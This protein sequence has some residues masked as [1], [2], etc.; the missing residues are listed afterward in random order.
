MKDYPKNFL[1][2]VAIVICGYI[3]NVYGQDQARMP[4][5]VAFT[6][7]EINKDL[8]QKINEDVFLSKVDFVNETIIYIFE[9]AINNEEDID[10]YSS[11]YSEEDIS[12]L[13]DAYQNAK[14][15]FFNANVG[16]KY[17]TTD[18]KILNQHTVSFKKCNKQLNRDAEKRAH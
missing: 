2:L 8:P 3:L 17:I 9:V 13:C 7:Q 6:I 12:R 11:P 18:G 16:E 10:H 14:F 15:R 5:L 4:E 1:V